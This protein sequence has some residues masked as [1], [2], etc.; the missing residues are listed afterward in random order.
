VFEAANF[1][2]R[3]VVIAIDHDVDLATDRPG[4]VDDE[5]GIDAKTARYEPSEDAAHDFLSRASILARMRNAFRE[6]QLFDAI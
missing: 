6:F 4:S 3:M 5:A 1:K 2:N